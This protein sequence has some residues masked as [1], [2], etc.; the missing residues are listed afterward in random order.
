M[1]RLGRV[2]GGW[3]EA[4]GVMVIVYHHYYWVKFR[5]FPHLRGVQKC[6]Y[7]ADA[8]MTLLGVCAIL[9]GGAQANI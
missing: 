1:D 4:A 6:R 8:S 3:L 2:G 9:C 5:C 7:R